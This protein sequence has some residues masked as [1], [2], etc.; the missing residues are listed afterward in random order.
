MVTI[1]MSLLA[2]SEQAMASAK[3]TKKGVLL[4]DYTQALMTSVH[5]FCV[6]HLESTLILRDTHSVNA[7]LQPH[8]KMDHC[9]VGAGTSS[10]L[11]GH[12]VSWLDIGYPEE[13]KYDFMKKSLYDEV[14]LQMVDNLME[15]MAKQMDRKFVYGQASSGA[16][17]EFF[18]MDGKGVSSSGALDFLI[19]GNGKPTPGFRLYV[20]MLKTEAAMLGFVPFSVDVPAVV[21]KALKV[22]GGEVQSTLQRRGPEGKPHIFEVN[23]GAVSYCMKVHQSTAAYDNENTVYDLGLVGGTKRIA[24]FDDQSTMTVQ[25]WATASLADVEFS[26][27]IFFSACNTAASVLEGMHVNNIGYCDASPANV[28]VEDQPD[29]SSVCYWN[30]YSHIVVLDDKPIE[31]FQGTLPYASSGMCALQ[32]QAVESHVYSQ[33]DDLE[34]VFYVLLSYAWNDGHRV[35]QLPWCKLLTDGDMVAR[36]LLMMADFQNQIMPSIQ[37]TVQATLVDLHV[38]V[39]TSKDYA[40]SLRVLNAAGASESVAP[41]SGTVSDAPSIE[42]SDAVFGARKFYHSAEKSHGHSHTPMS[43]NIAVSGGL[44]PCQR[45]FPPSSSSS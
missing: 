45:C 25:P 9:L 23:S 19:Q 8:H 33:I 21:L 18:R 10:A 35:R 5:R 15:I 17:I 34:A 32:L 12:G 40:V 29:G 26:P 42:E 43:K 3:M 4:E 41:E 11:D 22:V 39:F 36:R 24:R 30:D 28:L 20:H 37:A 44:A 27:G 6:G 14:R 1:G 38:A 16:K 7:P 31:Y 2:G 13:L